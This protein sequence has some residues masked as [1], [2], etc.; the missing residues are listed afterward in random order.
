MTIYSSRHRA[1]SSATELQ[2]CVESPLHF[3]RSQLKLRHPAHGMIP[4]KPTDEQETVV[5][6]ITEFQHT[7]YSHNRQVGSSTVMAAYAL[8]HSLFNNHQLTLCVL[9]SREMARFFLD[10][11]VSLNATIDSPPT[12]VVRRSLNE[13][14]FDNG[15]KIVVSEP[16]PSTGRGSTINLLM[17]CD[18]SYM[19][20]QTFY[21]MMSTL[22][23]TCRATTAKVI[24]HSGPG[25]N[26]LF[27]DLLRE[28]ASGTTSWV[29]LVLP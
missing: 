4:F 20:S 18:A 25:G 6:H 7:V 27:Y 1:V 2:R 12:K 13:I 22:L 16:Q 10:L 15:S 23:P 29:D 21:N 26:E 5:N 8:W 11:I 17:M 14:A 3:M 24:C 28:A 19:N 9:P